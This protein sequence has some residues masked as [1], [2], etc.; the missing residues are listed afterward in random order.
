MKKTCF[1]KSTN[2][3]LLIIMINYD[4]KDNYNHDDNDKNKQHLIKEDIKTSSSQQP[5]YENNLNP[6]LF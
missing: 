5:Q 4:H 6:F 2:C 3:Y 1:N